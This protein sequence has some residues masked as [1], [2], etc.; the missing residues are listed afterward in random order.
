MAVTHLFS[1]L[2]FDGPALF[3]TGYKKLLYDLFLQLGE[4]EARWFSD[5]GTN[6]W[7]TD[8]E[9]M[10]WA[11]EALPLAWLCSSVFINSTAQKKC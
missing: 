11:A 8:E 7:E 2:L 3:D 10:A 5:S 6:V 9:A 4:P 1:P